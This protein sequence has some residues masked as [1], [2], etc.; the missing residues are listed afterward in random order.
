[1]IA[2]GKVRRARAI[3]LLLLLVSVMLTTSIVQALNQTPKLTV[4]YTFYT[5]HYDISTNEDG[6]STIELPGYYPSGLPGDPS[7][8]AV[9][10][11]IALPP[12]VPLDSVKLTVGPFEQIEL[13]GIYQIEPVE[14]YWQARDEVPVEL[15]WGPNEASIVEGK[16]ALVYD[17]G[18]YFP[19]DPVQ[20]ETVSQ[21]RKWRFAEL[22]FWPV[23]YNPASG[24][25][26]LTSKITVTLHY[27]MPS[28]KRA[29]SA[30]LAD[31]LMDD[32]A[33]DM[34]AN[35]DVA[36]EWYSGVAEYR[37]GA[38]QPGY[39]IVTTNQIAEASEELDDFIAHKESL[40][41]NVQLVTE[42]QY[43]TSAL[44][45]RPHRVRQ[46]LQANYLAD[47]LNYV[48]LIGN[49]D[50]YAQ[51]HPE[52]EGVTD[53]I[54]GDMPMLLAD[55]WYGDI[56]D[57]IER[58]VPTDVYFA[59]LTG[60]WDYD[61]DGVYGAADDHVA[62]GV[63]YWA[64]V[65]VGRIPV[66]RDQP[67]EGPWDDTLDKILRKTIDYETSE[68]VAWRQ[69]A[70][71]PMSFLRTSSDG[72]EVGEYMKGDYL[73]A[74]GFNTYRMYWHGNAC[75]SVYS[76][77]E[78]LEDGVVREHWMNNPYGLV[79]FFGHGWY[80]NISLG[81]NDCDPGIDSK[82]MIHYTDAPYLDDSRPAMTFH[83]SCRTGWPEWPE[84]LGYALLKNGA[85]TTASG[86]RNLTG[87]AADP[88]PTSTYLAS[89]MY[90]YDKRLALS[91]PT[92]DALF[93]TKG[94]PDSTSNALAVNL[95]GDPSLQL[96]GGPFNSWPV[97]RP[98]KYEVDWNTTLTIPAP[99]VLANDT[100]ADGDQMAVILSEGPV[101][102][103]LSL[104][105]DGSF[106]YTPNEDFAGTD[107]FT[108]IVS[109]QDSFSQTLVPV[110]ITILERAESVSFTTA[111]RESE[112]N[113]SF[114]TA[115]AV[116]YV[117]GEQAIAGSV[118]PS[119][120]VDYFEIDPTHANYLLL[121]IDA[122]SAGSTLDSK[123]CLYGQDQQIIICSDDAYGMDSMI[124]VP[125]CQYDESYYLA[126]EGFGSGTGTYTLSLD[127]PTLASPESNG[128]VAGVVYQGEDILAH[129]SIGY[130]GSNTPYQEKWLLFFDGSD[131]DVNKNLTAF[132]TIGFC[133]PQQPALALTFVGKQKIID[134]TGVIWKST[135]HDILRFDVG[136]LGP[137]TRGSFA[138]EPI[139]NGRKVGLTTAS[140]KIDAITYLGGGMLV[141]TSGSANVPASG[142]G[143]VRAKDEDLLLVDLSPDFEAI[144]AWNLWFDGSEEVPGLA[145]EDL[146]AVSHEWIDTNFTWLELIIQGSGR[147]NGFPLTQA[148]SYLWYYDYWE[149]QEPGF[150]FPFAVDALD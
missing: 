31:T 116:G 121:D 61:G 44:E 91:Y 127:Y 96:F 6:Y 13:P 115:D 94:S 63:D 14:P 20:L 47:N 95:Y 35:Y 86:S 126:V 15:D 93:V 145:S 70:L 79:T 56:K 85:V 78:D 67:G 62:G 23:S 118:Y 146:Y 113:D 53:E 92:G 83:A 112:P 117:Y 98:D 103:R 52:F 109:D 77:E 32:Q 48:L 68:D 4:T 97:G 87:H 17:A 122:K 12:G 40:G 84:N 49:P 107:G 30:E 119:G 38:P 149:N 2:L 132:D 73:D 111:N 148:D 99:G 28:S 120:D 3:A 1:M 29:T 65:Y 59:D 75:N 37:S 131:I 9:L 46:W 90:Y 137:N 58:G 106:T 130:E 33:A 54:V 123:M 27:Q 141:S 82:T 143:N 25:L 19:S 42:N 64:E 136:Q 57:P 11:Y 128:K 76:S 45:E 60:N 36:Q 80:S 108:Y 144:P 66:Y 69:S 110:R 134:S 114:D 7:L 16:N 102:G 100:D 41:F 22:R 101:F 34:L 72:A 147:V 88:R 140:E 129:T 133:P 39:A 150:S 104:A 24:R 71:L 10:S 142:S 74:L 55:E 125:N 18:E 50:P 26:R 105:D 139:L 8:P 135:R 138:P 81:F 124:F 21:M 89:F 43:G 51:P 5:P